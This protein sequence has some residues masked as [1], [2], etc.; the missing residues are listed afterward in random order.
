MAIVKE[1]ISRCPHCDVF[2]NAVLPEGDCHNCGE[3][4][5]WPHLA[6]SEQC[7]GCWQWVMP[8]QDDPLPP[9]GEPGLWRSC[10]KCAGRFNPV[11]TANPLVVIGVVKQYFGCVYY[12]DESHQE[13]ERALLL[14]IRPLLKKIMRLQAI[15]KGEKR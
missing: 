7:D 3:H 14:S 2:A 11:N 13:Q 12:G 8:V 10:P 15:I 1:E 4:I 9:F 5:V 6:G